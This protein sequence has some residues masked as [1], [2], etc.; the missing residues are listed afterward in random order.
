MASV[1]KVYLAGNLTRDPELRR[2]PSGVAVTDLRM[3][4]NDSYKDKDG[5]NVERTC[6]VDVVAWDRLAEQCEASLSKGSPIVVEGRLQLDEWKTKEGQPRSK[7]RVR[8]EDIQ[9]LGRRRQA[10]GA[11]D[12]GEAELPPEQ[13]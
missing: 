12:A 3:A 13:P 1:N 7:L 6:F 9:F 8:A 10:D 4:I 2:I 5:K 11:G